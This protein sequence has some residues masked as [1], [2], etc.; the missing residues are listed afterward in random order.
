LLDVLFGRRLGGGVLGHHRDDGFDANI[1]TGVDAAE[2]VV[3]GTGWVA[4]YYRWLARQ[5]QPAL[6]GAFSGLALSTLMLWAFLAVF[7]I[8][9]ETETLQRLAEAQAEVERIQKRT[10]TY[11]EAIQNRLMIGDAPALDAFG[12]ALEYNVKGSRLIG[13]FTLRAYGYDGRK[14]ADDLC[15]GG[16]TK[17]A[18]LTAKARDAALYIRRFTKPDRARDPSVTELWAALDVL[19]C[20]AP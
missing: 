11:P 8:P 4:R 15:V 6:L 12:R 20:D 17:L 14:S 10:G 19:R 3:A 7:V 1:E 13:S 18:Q 5:Q 16:A 9:K 2:G